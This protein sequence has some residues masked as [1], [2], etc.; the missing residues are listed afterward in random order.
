LLQLGPGE[1]LFDA[2]KAA[3]GKMDIIA[4]DLVRRLCQIEDQVQLLEKTHLERKAVKTRYW[5]SL[6]RA[7]SQV[8]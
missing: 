1:E 7:S 8:M 3:V 2:V 6:F 4:E 5:P